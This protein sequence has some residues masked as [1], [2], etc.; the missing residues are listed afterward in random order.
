MVIRLHMW[1]SM[2]EIMQAAIG[3]GPPLRTTPP[4]AMGPFRTDQWRGFWSS[5][6]AGT[7]SALGWRRVGLHSPLP[8]QHGRRMM[9]VLPFHRVVTL[10]RIGEREKWLRKSDVT[11]EG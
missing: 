4:S 10:G 3:P 9:Q 2:I 6:R 5:R 7:E 8:A 1:E 11:T